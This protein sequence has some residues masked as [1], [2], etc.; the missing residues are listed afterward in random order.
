M[1]NC[2]FCKII[3]NTI[4][5]KKIYE[6]KYILAFEDANPKAN[7]HLLVIPKKHISTLIDMQETDLKLMGHLTLL[8]PKIAEMSG[9][10]DGFRTAINTGKA[11]GQEIYHI[12][13]HILGKPI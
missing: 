12:H 3:D 9:L 2:L 13:Y 11:G 4:P 6:D 10:K 8:L 1:K 7:P 5:A